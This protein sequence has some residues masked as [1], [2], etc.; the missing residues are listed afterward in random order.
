MP[1]VG[2][3]GLSRSGKSTVFSALTNIPYSFSSD[4]NKVGIVKVSDER[5]EYLRDLYKPLKYTPAT[6]EFVD[7]KGSNSTVKGSLNSSLSSVREVDCLAIV[8]RGFVLD[9][10]DTNYVDDLDNLL[11]ELILSDYSQ[12]ERR[13]ERL[14]KKLKAKENGA[15]EEKL[16][17][18]KL[19]LRYAEGLIYRVEE[20]DSKEQEIICNFNLL[21][22]KKMIC[23][24]NISEQEI[25][26]IETSS[27]YLEL[28]DKCEKLGFP[29]LYIAA[30]IELEINSLEK[31]EEKAYFMESY[32]LVSLASSKVIKEAFKC[33]GLKTYFTAG[34]PEVRAWIFKEGYKAPDCAG[35]IHSDFKNGFIRAE[36]LSFKDL[37]T[38]KTPQLA[39]SNG[40]YRLE[41]KEY[42]VEDGDI[43]LF[44]FNV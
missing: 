1:N 15:F 27:K 18:E 11:L 8:I 33:L 37:L 6:F 38:Y 7:I 16:L 24:L 32:N 13:L 10:L 2:I 22:L 30:N 44:R 14:E 4:T 12:L 28:K 17:I 26:S 19:L 25:S 3:I 9:G 29:L 31:E 20:L 36:T 23:I 35:I 41:G 40:K 21:S 34:T 43:M 42:L 5:L 39:R